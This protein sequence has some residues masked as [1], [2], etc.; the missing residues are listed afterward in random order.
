MNN[1][2]LLLIGSCCAAMLTLGIGTEVHA[3]QQPGTNV[4]TP[5]SIS[6]A[7]S[8]PGDLPETAVPIAET[9]L[10][11]EPVI[12][13]EST[14]KILPNRPL[15]LTGAV[16]LAGSY[17]ASAIVA[18]TSDRSAD[19]KLYYPVVGPWMDLNRRGCDV[20]VC[21]NNTLDRALLIGD[22]IIQGVGALG[23]LLS[24]VVPEKA[25]RHW[26]LIGNDQLMVFPQF[27][28]SRLGVG[29]VSRF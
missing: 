3:Q 15:L 18:A 26:Y 19:D 6:A 10:A 16:L 11:P 14:K 1:R 12:D 4:A 23:M 5:T 25:T 22:G 2:Y 21:S 9:G 20:Q 24:L 8:Q 13:V 17:G 29:V 7:T 27:G 28:Q